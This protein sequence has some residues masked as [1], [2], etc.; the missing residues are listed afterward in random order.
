MV[1]AEILTRQIFEERAVRSAPNYFCTRIFLAR[2][3]SLTQKKQTNTHYTFGGS[4]CFLR[5]VCDIEL[6][7]S[8]T[9]GFLRSVMEYA[10]DLLALHLLFLH[11]SCIST[12]T[13]D[14]KTAMKRIGFMKQR[15][16]LTGAG[17]RSTKEYSRPP[18]L[19]T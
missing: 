12:S 4:N 18:F 1:F 17:H 14:T 5:Y 6:L 2:N 10:T 9:I 16:D 8:E 7:R 19:L 3:I 13:S 11:P 15:N